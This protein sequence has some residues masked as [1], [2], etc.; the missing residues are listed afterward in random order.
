MILELACC[1][2]TLL[3]EIGNTVF[4]Q[5]DVAKTYA[6]AMRS[7]EVK[8]IDWGKVNRAIIERWSKSGLERIKQ[9]AHSGKAF[10]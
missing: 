7:S 8:K 5:K 6:L 1:E 3:Q 2:A 9:L 10:E 4:K